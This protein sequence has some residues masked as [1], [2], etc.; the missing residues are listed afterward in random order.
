[1]LQGVDKPKFGHLKKDPVF[2][3]YRRFKYEEMS[4]AVQRITKNKRVKL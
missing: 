1:M 4:E 2:G 3:R